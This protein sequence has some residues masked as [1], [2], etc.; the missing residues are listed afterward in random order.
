MN[1]STQPC[2]APHE[3][4]YINDKKTLNNKCKI[5]TLEKYKQKVPR[6]VQQYYFMKEKI[7]E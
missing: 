6:K 3:T 7:Y 1:L 2:R 5:I 4:R